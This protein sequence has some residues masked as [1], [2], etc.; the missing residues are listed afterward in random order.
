MSNNRAILLSPY[1]QFNENKI[2][3]VT[4]GILFVDMCSTPGLCNVMYVN[5]LFLSFDYDFTAGP[6]LLEAILKQCNQTPSSSIFRSNP[7]ESSTKV[8]PITSEQPK[9]PRMDNTMR[10]NNNRQRN[11]SRQSRVNRRQ[12]NGGGTYNNTNQ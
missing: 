3:L 2:L 11:D 1:P 5:G 8:E 4:E 10:S 7:I 6:M 9:S 12:S